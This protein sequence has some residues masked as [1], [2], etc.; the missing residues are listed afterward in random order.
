[1]ETYDTDSTD[2]RPINENNYTGCFYS[3][4]LLVVTIAVVTYI[5]INYF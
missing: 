4:I 5:V 3:F 2:D 1:M